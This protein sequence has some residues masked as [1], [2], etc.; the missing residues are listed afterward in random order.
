MRNVL[1]GM[2]IVFCLAAGC[3][4]I[5]DKIT[6]AKIPPELAAYAGKDPNHI[7]YPSLEKLN[8]LTFS[9][10]IKHICTQ[11]ELAYQIEKDTKVFSELANK[12]AELKAEAER[13][14]A[15]AFGPTGIL[16]LVLGLLGGGSTVGWIVSWLKS[17]TMYAETEHQ[18][19][20][21]LAVEKT[22]NSLKQV[23]YT[24]EE[25]QAKITAAVAATKSIT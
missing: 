1:L 22:T 14:K 12:A 25:V 17:Q 15:W 5:Q 20:L 24:E 3:A 16:T 19:L 6:P 18:S 10:N 9:A 8:K 13:D 23:L 11:A 7:G 2:S 4:F 21:D